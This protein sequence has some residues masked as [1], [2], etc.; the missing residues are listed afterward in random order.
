M[1]FDLTASNHFASYLALQSNF[2]FDSTGAQRRLNGYFRGDLSTDE[3]GIVGKAEDAHSTSVDR[4]HRRI[5]GCTKGCNS[6]LL[7]DTGHSLPY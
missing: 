5:R 4:H 3:S 2:S 6:V 7:A 1:Q